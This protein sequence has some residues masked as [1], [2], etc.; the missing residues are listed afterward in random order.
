MTERLAAG[1]LAHDPYRTVLEVGSTL[2]ATLDLDRVLET[3]AR[4]IGEALDVQYCDI[5]DY[6]HATQTLRC[7]AIWTPTPDP[8]EEAFVGTVTAVDERIGIEGVLGRLGVLEE[9]VDDPALPE[10]ERQLMEE[11][12]ELASLEVPLVCGGVVIGVLCVAERA[13]TRRRFTDDEKRLFTLL[14]GPAAVAIRN[15]RVWRARVERARRLRALLDASRAISATMDLD[16]VLQRIARAAVDVAGASQSAIYEYRVETDSI[17]YRAVYERFAAPDAEPDDDL[18][19]AYPLAAYPGERAILENGALVEEHC[20]DPDLP[21]DR[22]ASMEAWGEK[23]VLS[24]PLHFRGDAV[25]ILR[26]YDMVEERHFDTTDR[27]LLSSLGEL[28]SAAL[29]NARLLRRQ[30]EQATRLGSLVE[31]TTTLCAT[32]DPAEVVAAVGEGAATVLGAGTAVEVWLRTDAGGLAPADVAIAEDAEDETGGASVAS[33]PPAIASEALA[34]RVPVQRADHDGSALALSMVAKEQVEGFV[35]FAVPGYRLFTGSEV[36]T[37]EV[38][39][40]QAAVTLA[41]A[42]LYRQ[43]QRLAVRDGLTG[44]YNHRCFQERLAQECARAN[45]FG[46]PLSLLMID[47]DDFKRF[48]D[49][50]G[51]QLGDEVLREIGRVLGGGLRRGIDVP[52]R[53]GGEEFAVILPHTAVSGAETAGRRLRAELAAAGVPP[54]GAGAVVVGERL[55]AT[56]ETQA[57]AGHGGRRYAHLTVS[58]GVAGCDAGGCR[59]DDLVGRADRALYEAKRRGKN[60]VAVDGVDPGGGEQP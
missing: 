8:R 5:H 19:S 10:A 42:R 26:L 35:V 44:L 15:A 57:F 28:A 31:T 7:V 34:R 22:R 27:E 52:A 32:F 43:V 18:G 38:L 45:R 48:N 17:V 4:R 54:P 60:R 24:V 41:N 58:V 53:Y 37:L 47:I 33:E 50:H 23:T 39:V 55:R 14:A 9:Y 36:E 1:H 29:H 56:V 6:D 12:G 13:H 21:A 49:D 11:W 51:H 3:V 16:E 40:R 25:G 30:E 20:S 59:P 2:T 46:L